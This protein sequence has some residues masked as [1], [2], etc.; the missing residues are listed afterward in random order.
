MPVTHFTKHYKAVLSFFLVFVLAVGLLPPALA[1]TPEEDAQ[2]WY[3]PAENQEPL[4][5]L[6]TRV[7]IAWVH[8]EYDGPCGCVG[9]DCDSGV[10]VLFISDYDPHWEPYLGIYGDDIV[11]SEI[12]IGDRNLD[13]PRSMRL[14]NNRRD[15]VWIENGI[16]V[17]DNRDINVVNQSNRTDSFSPFDPMSSNVVIEM[18]KIVRIPDIL[19]IMQSGNLYVYCVNNPVM[20][21][22]PTGERSFWDRFLDGAFGVVVTAGG[23]LG[24]AAA[25]AVTIGT[26]PILG[27]GALIAGAAVYV[28]GFEL[29][30]GG[31]TL[32]FRSFE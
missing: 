1:M 25:P 3:E 23:I 15:N 29:V 16:R 11:E 10:V 7:L 30:I 14:N 20:F 17:I 27:G 8:T 26:A 9:L 28:A 12:I 22:D 19:V 13:I 5:E 2:G 24:I 18:N 32:F 4:D 21:I 6:E 31:V